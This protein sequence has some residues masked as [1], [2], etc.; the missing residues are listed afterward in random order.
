[1]AE[2]I[3][4]LGV[5]ESELRRTSGG[6]RLIGLADQRR[7]FPHRGTM[8]LDAEALVLGD[9]R[10]IS[11]TTIETAVVSFT[12]AYTRFMAGGSRGNSPSLGFLG[13]LGKPLI[14]TL[15]DEDRIYLLLGFRWWTGINQARA[16]APEIQRWI[17]G[18]TSGG[19]Q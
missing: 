10:S 7:L 11:R 17:T 14:L 13:S 19:T 15:R 1:M 16:R 2:T 18:T 8:R 4:Y 6:H 5:T 12:V 3:T 9:W